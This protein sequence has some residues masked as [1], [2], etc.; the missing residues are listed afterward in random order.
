MRRS[1]WLRHC[2]TSREDT[3]SI[4]YGVDGIFYLHNTSSR[5]MTLDRISLKPEYQK[6]FLE[7]KAAGAYVCEL[8]Q[9]HMST[10]HKSGIFQTPGTL[11]VCN[12]TVIGMLYLNFSSGEHF[13]QTNYSQIWS[14]GPRGGHANF[15]TGQNNF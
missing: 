10:V 6:Y 12:R 4:L 7:V 3:C 11:C 13:L 1:N 5:T 9:F 8:Y 15:L 14:C 2:A